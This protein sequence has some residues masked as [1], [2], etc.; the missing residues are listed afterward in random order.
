[1]TEATVTQ[2]LVVIV[3]AIV[4]TAAFIMWVVK[5]NRKLTR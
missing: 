5:Q 2:Q 3:S 1:M 4:I